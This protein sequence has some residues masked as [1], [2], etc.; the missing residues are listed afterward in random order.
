M[1]TLWGALDGRHKN[2]AGAFHPER[3]GRGAGEE[4]WGRN[5]VDG[6]EPLLTRPE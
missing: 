3:F 1:A 6:D 2:V 4:P 5:P